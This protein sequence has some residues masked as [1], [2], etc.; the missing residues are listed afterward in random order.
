[1]IKRVELFLKEE[2]ATTSMFKSE[3]SFPR[4]GLLDLKRF[5]SFIDK[6]LNAS[7]PSSFSEDFANTFRDVIAVQHKEIS[8]GFDRLC[9]VED[10][11]RSDIKTSELQKFSHAVI[12]QS[13]LG[14]GTNLKI[15]RS[16]FFPGNAFEVKT[17]DGK[18]EELGFGG[19]IALKPNQE[20]DYY[21]KRE[22]LEE[23]I[24]KY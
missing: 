3:S 7:I 9:R 22:T 1:M 6:G 5:V 18:R 17:P 15:K 13:L 4:F 20:F 19:I 11:K 16:E 24:N 12:L 8:N 23:D 21:W 14:E 2:G 10:W